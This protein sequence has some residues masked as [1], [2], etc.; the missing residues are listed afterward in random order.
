MLFPTFM[1]LVYNLLLTCVMG[2][3]VCLF[4]VGIE[5]HSDEPINENEQFESL[6]NNAK[7]IDDLIDLQDKTKQV[8]LKSKI[9]YAIAEV[10]RKNNLSKWPGNIF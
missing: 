3:A 8:K 6:L 5:C 1:I 2:G 10:Y 9:F 7:T 4:L